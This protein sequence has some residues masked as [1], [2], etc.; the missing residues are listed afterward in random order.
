MAVALT[1]ERFKA[2]AGFI[3]LEH[4]VFSLPVIFAG[5]VLHLL[6]WPDAGLVGLILLAA[7]GARVVAMG[8]NRLIDAGIDA[9]NPRTKQR[10]LPRG[11]MRRGEA[12][13][14]VLGAGA[15]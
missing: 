1:G 7:V 12:G 3:K 10:E 13:G 14:I 4:T 9:C 6:R 15:P 11:A 5:A 8:L 2:Y